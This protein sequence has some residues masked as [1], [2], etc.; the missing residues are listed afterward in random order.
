MNNT[1]QLQQSV[2]GQNDL[3]EEL[4]TYLTEEGLNG[5][6]TASQPLLLRGCTGSGKSA[7][8]S[9]LANNVYGVTGWKVRALIYCNFC[10]EI[11]RAM[12]F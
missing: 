8:A 4:E 10:N 9:V 7:I 1:L 2:L 6:K 11:P 12:P 3:V 5:N